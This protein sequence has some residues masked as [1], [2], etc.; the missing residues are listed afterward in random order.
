MTAALL[1]TLLLAADGDVTAG[2]I[3]FRPHRI[4]AFAG[5]YQVSVADMHGDGGPDVIALSERPSALAWY[6]SPTWTK[7]PIEL[8]GV[9]QLIDVAP[10]EI[11]GDGRMDLAIASD[12]A[13]G[14]SSTG[15]VHWLTRG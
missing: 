5:G 4:D 8:P 3:R 15:R 1:G 2:P 14:N 11:D 6:E 7:H 13:L 9:K 10:Q 12:F